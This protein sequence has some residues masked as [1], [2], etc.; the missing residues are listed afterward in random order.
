VRRRRLFTSVSAL[1]LL[2]FVSVCVL[3]VRSYWRTDTIRFHSAGGTFFVAASSEGVLVA[4]RADAGLAPRSRRWTYSSH[5]A[6][7]R[8]R[9]GSYNAR[10]GFALYARDD[11][12]NL[13][14]P[15]AAVAALAGACVAPAVLSFLRRRRRTKAG[16]CPACGYDLRATPGRCP[17]CGWAAGETV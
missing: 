9:P 14:V 10:F 16:L 6:G 3:W 17:E 8:W 1:S 2:L 12:H 7:S 4:G 15:H 13:L 11:E 5:A